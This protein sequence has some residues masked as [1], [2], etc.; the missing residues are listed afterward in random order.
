MATTPDINRFKILST[1]ARTGAKLKVL[2]VT[3]G[4]SVEEIQALLE[5]SGLKAI[6]ENRLEEAEEKFPS[7]P[8]KMEKHFI[9]K[10]QSRKIPRIAELF[11][12]IQSVENL[13]Q[14]QALAKTGKAL[15]IFLQIN[16]SGLPGR[17]GC[18]WEEAPQL[19][20]ALAQ[21]PPLELVGVMGIATQDPKAARLQ[22]RRLK[23]LQ[24]TLP[25]CS[26]G[27]SDDY[28]IAIE[29]GSTMLRLGRILFPR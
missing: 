14:A 8:A 2:P 9:G 7:L 18:T 1:L 24:G 28:A 20:E 15:K 10:L 21:L 29:E 4:R 12:V 6:A 19:L 23:S 27:M 13:K 17:S 5:Q 26:M 22:M 25:H 11:D 3:K 16:I